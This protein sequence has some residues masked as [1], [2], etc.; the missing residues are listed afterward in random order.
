MWERLHTLSVAEAMWNGRG[1]FAGNQPDVWTARH[2]GFGSSESDIQMAGFV[3][4]PVHM[5]G[6]SVSRYCSDPTGL[7]R[8]SYL[9]GSSLIDAFPLGSISV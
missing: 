2:P 6:M 7:F 9:L 5:Q 1:K 4:V 8:L 3:M